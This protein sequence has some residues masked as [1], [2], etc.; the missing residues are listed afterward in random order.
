MPTDPKTPNVLWIFSDKFGCGTY[1]CYT[2][3]L[4]L[5]ELG[6]DNHFT[7]HYDFAPDQRSFEWLDN[8]NLVV[9]QRAVGTF[10]RAAM[11]ECRRRNIPV[12]FE[13]DDD[14]FN[15]HKSNPSAP[16]W[17]RPAIQRIL[18]E[19]I[20]L[21]DHVI[22]STLPLKTTIVHEVGC[23][24]SK[25]TVCHNHLREEMWGPDI[26]GVDVQPRFRNWRTL[27]NGTDEEYVVIGWQGSN[28][29]DNDFRHALPALSRIV[30]ERSNVVVRFFGNVPLT[31]RG[32]IP[33]DRFQWS[34]GVDFEF[35][36][37]QLAYMNFDIG[38]APVTDSKFNQAKSNLKW[39]EY[40]SIGVPTVASAV[41][42]YAQSIEQGVTGI[43]CRTDD[44]WY[45]A[46]TVL[47][48]NPSERRA[49]GERA[50]AHVWQHWG[51]TRAHAWADTF[52]ALL[53]QHY[54]EQLLPQFARR[55]GDV[56]DVA[57][58]ASLGLP[59]PRPL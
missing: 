50:K 26:T 24:G 35:Y 3:A 5:Q 47:I 54:G 36:P 6:F 40:S 16:F 59:A 48:D 44:D 19:E 49:M 37:A 33:E 9:F 28:T 56:P 21:A 55:A 42:P 57:D 1:R 20:E 13:T 23:R 43:I 38:I 45:E 51:K 12:V 29:H 41:Y 11:V 52:V 27:A 58:L 2:P 32:H 53:R 34:R 31:V 10:F 15:I 7:A 39:L 25:V 8:M 30:K 4:T 14:L 18:R 17:H 22:A 46:L